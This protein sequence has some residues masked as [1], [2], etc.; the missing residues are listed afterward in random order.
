MRKTRVGLW[1]GVVVTMLVASIGAGEE[2][3]ARAGSAREPGTP[4]TPTALMQ[5]PTVPI[6]KVP[7]AVQRR[8]ETHL[9]EQRGADRAWHDAR[10]LAREALPIFEADTTEPTHY[11][12]A[13][14]GNHGADAGYIVVAVTPT[15]FPIPEGQEG[16][17]DVLTLLE[18]AR[19]G[20]G[21]IARV[22]R[23]GV[24]SYSAE[25]AGGEELARIGRLPMKPS[26]LTLAMLDLSAE[27]RA[28][29]AFRASNVKEDR[30]PQ[31]PAITAAPYASYEEYRRQHAQDAIVGRAS[32]T[33]AAAAA[34]ADERALA[35][36]PLVLAPYAAQEI[37]LLEGRGEASLTVTGESMH[38]ARVRDAA[39]RD[40]LVI[41]GRADAAY[42]GEETRIDLHYGDGSE[43]HLRFAGLR[44]ALLGLVPP[45]SLPVP[46]SGGSLPTPHPVVPTPGVQ[47]TPA[48]PLA[49]AAACTTEQGPQLVQLTGSP[50][51]SLMTCATGH[52]HLRSTTE[53]FVGLTST[54]DPTASIPYDEASSVSLI[55]AEPGLYVVMLHPMGR[56]TAR[57]LAVTTMTGG[58]PTP[59]APVKLSA[60]PVSLKPPRHAL[61]RIDMTHDGRFAF[62][63]PVA[64]RYLA[65]FR[66]GV[67][68]VVQPPMPPG[69][70]CENTWPD[71]Q[72]LPMCIS[73]TGEVW[74][75]PEGNPLAA[76]RDVRKYSQIQGW[77]APNPSGCYSGCAA[78]A[79]AMMF[80]WA[81]VRASVA[82]DPFAA[83]G[84]GLFRTGATRSGDPAAV[85]PE[86]F[87]T[88]GSDVHDPQHSPI[89][90]DAAAM[91]VE[92]RGYLDN[93]AVTGCSLN[94]ERFTAPAVMAQAFQYYQG[95]ANISLTAD[96]DGALVNTTEGREKAKNVMTN[97]HR[98][99]ILGIGNLGNQDAHYPLGVGWG[100]S[101]YQLWNRAGGQS[102]VTHDYFVVY[103]GF[104][105]R[106][107]TQVGAATW[108]QGWLSPT[109][110]KNG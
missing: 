31:L 44:S 60:I 33:R 87:Y 52:A 86:W 64:G 92:I 48:A 12:I 99:V 105:N 3:I 6:A 82:G 81:D 91:T 19:T 103:M 61:F 32:G 63:S 1:G 53:Q 5:A 15:D 29:H 17:P 84:A 50:P 22:V 71:T 75:H 9:R 42:D 47:V 58:V 110:D 37:A 69:R 79:W 78:T 45:K 77:R 96:Y 14:Q 4:T 89:D 100:A 18:G 102:S 30:V 104:G 56:G 16:G 74:G 88:D 34:W 11:A 73:T 80:G 98:P 70:L 21:T 95:R 46:T 36:L 49:V 20:P 68:D 26:G 13:V 10:G 41:T 24:G 57:E 72:F 40:V 8:A 66:N 54:G 107:F 97:K 23:H 67:L 59:G 109:T 83:N 39:G 62:Y 2:R 55:E 65:G 27:R 108:F 35:D 106:H 25:G 93:W 28:G 7:V 85:A 90:A 94:G 43:E 101:T 76:F 38:V 51:G